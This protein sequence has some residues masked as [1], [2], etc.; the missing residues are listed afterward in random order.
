MKCL[1]KENLEQT[2]IYLDSI[3]VGLGFPNGLDEMAQT[4][5]PPTPNSSW[6]RLKARKTLALKACG[7]CSVLKKVDELILN[8]Y[9]CTK[10]GNSLGTKRLTKDAESLST[11]NAKRRKGKVVES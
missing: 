3:I 8:N 11:S 6:T 1:E 9:Q 2:H 10:K 7:G 4:K 5:L